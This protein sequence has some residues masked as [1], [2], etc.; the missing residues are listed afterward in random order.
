MTAARASNEPEQLAS[1]L[2]RSSR[3]TLVLIHGLDSAKDTW[4]SVQAELQ[5][6]QYPS[7]A[8]D[9]RGHGESPLGNETS[10][11]HEQLAADIR[12]AVIAHGVSRPFVLLGHSMGGMV[13]MN[14]AAMYPDDVAALMIEDMDIRARNPQ[15]LDTK[16]MQRCE[17]F[18]TIYPLSN[19]QPPTSNSTEI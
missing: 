16:E 18:T 13:V 17:I 6:Q 10:F 5:K 9:L 12:A 4:A 3:P 15:N 8:L 11:N 14:Y 1:S 19:P 7:L 2:V